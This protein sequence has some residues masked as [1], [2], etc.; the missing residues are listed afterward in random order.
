V[1]GVGE[2]SVL[3]QRAAWV[4]VAAYA[5]SLVYELWRATAKAGTTRHDSM[6]TFLTQDLLLYVLASVVITLLLVDVRGA[7]W[8]GLAFTVVFILVSILS[9]NPRIMLEREPG[10]LDWTEDLVYTGLLFVA[11]SLLLYEVLGGSLALG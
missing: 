3:Q 5:L 4:L 11:G 10:L 9:Y 6:R 7:A 2:A 1:R 8:I